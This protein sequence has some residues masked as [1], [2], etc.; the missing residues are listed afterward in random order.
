MTDQL[1]RKRGR[2]RTS[3]EKRRA[4]A[5]R[6]LDAA[7]K[8][9]E[10]WGYDKTTIDDIAREAGVAKGTI[11]LHWKTR[12]DLFM[13][14]IM[15]EA[16]AVIE[17]LQKYIVENADSFAFHT[18]FPYAFLL[19]QQRPLVKALLT[20]DAS[21]L[22]SVA[23]HDYLQSNSIARRKVLFAHAILE[24]MQA[25]GLLRSDLSLRR[26]EYMLAAIFIG[27]MTLDP[28]WPE[29][30]RLPL[31]Q[32]AQDLGEAIRLSLES[33]QLPPPERRRRLAHLANEHIASFVAAIRAYLEQYIPG[34]SG[35]STHDSSDSSQ[36][37]D[38]VLRSQSRHS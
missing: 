5:E 28:L 30:E 10:R 35:G 22:G 9:I 3:P 1:Q 38:E 34:I 2:A 21:L 31:E 24:Q 33:Q 14:V 23:Q 19:Y 7:V 16:L 32:Q 26:L 15:R 11:Y 36:R 8:L 4:R 6:I 37:P 13:A 29:E 27:Y 18:F 20:N 12:E 25:E 17:S